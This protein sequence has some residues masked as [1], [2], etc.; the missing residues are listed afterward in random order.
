MHC[1]STTYKAY[2]ADWVRLNIPTFPRRRTRRAACRP[3]L[4]PSFLPT[5]PTP[6]P[7]HHYPSTTT[8]LHI[9]MIILGLMYSAALPRGTPP[10]LYRTARPRADARAIPGAA[11]QPLTVPHCTHLP[12]CRARAFAPRCYISPKRGINITAPARAHHHLCTRC[13][14]HARTPATPPTITLN[15]LVVCLPAAPSTAPPSGPP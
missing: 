4:P 11:P 2:A 8:A 1:A 14:A 3:Y 15:H 10:A 6:L 5:A 7:C 9:L 12:T 13:G